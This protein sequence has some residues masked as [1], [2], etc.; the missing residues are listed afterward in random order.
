MVLK[1]KNSGKKMIPLFSHALIQKNSIQ[2][3]DLY[4]LSLELKRQT[5]FDC[6]FF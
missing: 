4:G 5:V 3:D 6:Y 1:L 2:K